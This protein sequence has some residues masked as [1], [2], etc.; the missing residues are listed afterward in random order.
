[1]ME[2]FRLPNGL[3]FYRVIRADLRRI[4]GLGICDS[5]NSMP[6]YGFLVLVLGMYLCPECF[7]DW[8]QRCHYYPK[9]VGMNVAICRYGKR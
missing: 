5:C 1:M 6:S 8:R 2:K 3:Y 9:I 7:E 4:G